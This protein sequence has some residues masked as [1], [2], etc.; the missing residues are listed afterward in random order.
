MGKFAKSVQAI[1]LLGGV[2]ISE[3]EVDQASR[4]ST[5]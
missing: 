4:Y 2:A 3:K 1:H 5:R